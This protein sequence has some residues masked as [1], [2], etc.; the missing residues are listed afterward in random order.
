MA[1]PLSIKVTDIFGKTWRF[2]QDGK[3]RLKDT[4]SGLM[5]AEYEF[6]EYSAPGMAGVV[7]V[8]REDKVN[9]IGC[10]VYVDGPKGAEGRNLLATWRRAHGRGVAR[11]P[12]GPLMEFKVEDTGRFQMVRATF[13]NDPDLVKM[14]AIGKVLDEVV[15]RSDETWWRT[16][17]VPKSFTPA[18]FATATVPNR[19]DEPSWPHYRI[20]GPLTGGTI[21]LM[22]EAL[23]L[24]T[25]TA[26]QWLEINTDPDEWTAIDQAG[27]DRSDDLNG[28]DGNRWHTR[29]PVDDK[30]IPVTITG[31]DTT[32]S[33]LVTVTV[34]QL[35]WTAL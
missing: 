31:T 24:P 18:Q 30:A 17:P 12:D 13:K 25:L 5:G 7:V 3:V 1:L 8:D 23:T 29:A 20:V 4:P 9:N 32:G 21:G 33:T 28:G 2:N 27:L 19:G 10:K 34:P 26:G 16:K 35:F 22:G 14:F 15:Y 6:D 11:Q